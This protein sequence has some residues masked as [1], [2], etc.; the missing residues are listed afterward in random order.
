MNESEQTRLGFPRK[1]IFIIAAAA[2]I[3]LLIVG[4]PF[5]VPLIISVLLFNFIN[6]LSERLSTVHLGTWHLPVWL[7]TIVSIGL[8]VAF[9]SA[10]GGVV[11]LQIDAVAEVGPLYVV[12]FG[13]ITSNIMSF[14]GPQM[15]PWATEAMASIDY[16]GALTAVVD[17]T[18]AFFASFVLVVIYT[19][20]MLAEK[21]SI[22]TKIAA[23]YPNQ[24][25]DLNAQE[26]VAAIGQRLSSYIWLKS[27]MSLLTAVASYLVLKVVGVD[28]AET[29][30]ILIF[31]L[32]YI[33]NIGSMLAVLFP[34]VLSIVQFDTMTPTVIITVSLIAIQFVLGNIIEPKFMGRSLNLGSFVII[35]SLSFWGALWGVPGMFLSVPIMVI[36][37]IICSSVPEWRMVAVLLSTDGVIDTPKG[38]KP[39]RTPEESSQQGAV[40]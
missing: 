39:S 4:R 18:G 34:V 28:F 20:F 32:N 21:K 19:G 1:S 30:A 40:Q 27:M 25:G 26:I 8:A 24:G 33:P 7:A 16:V 35:L 22:P 6:T 36:V 17:S 37:M 5:L 14:L 29:W 15:M 3:A 38:A 13:E 31:L 9:L 12:R 10:I 11:S 23:L 2:I